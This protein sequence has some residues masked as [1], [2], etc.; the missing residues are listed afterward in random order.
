LALMK[1]KQAV[2]DS[3]KPRGVASQRTPWKADVATVVLTMQAA[4]MLLSRYRAHMG[5]LRR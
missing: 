1:R 5:L 3:R 2:L 4:A